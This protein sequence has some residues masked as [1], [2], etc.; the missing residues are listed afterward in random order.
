M[1]ALV[2]DVPYFTLVPDCVCEV[3][4]PGT[5]KQDRIEKLPL[6]ARERV[7]HAWLV[8]P[9]LRT[10]EAL[11][12]E[13]GRWV[14]VGLWKDDAKVHAEPFEAFELDLSVLW[15]DVVEREP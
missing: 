5:A 12:L 7:G 4:S 8:D 9:R 14:V 13:A 6:Y 1:P 2:D 10:L 15:A 3:L 11:R